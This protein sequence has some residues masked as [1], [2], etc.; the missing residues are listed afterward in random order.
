MHRKSSDAS[1][2]GT[3][4]RRAELGNGKAGNV[5][6]SMARADFVLTKTCLTAIT[7]RLGDE[8]G[9]LWDR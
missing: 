4:A 5:L 7:R 3:D 2:T 6:D 9:S 8:T 1:G